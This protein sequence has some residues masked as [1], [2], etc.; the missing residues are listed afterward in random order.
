M[1]VINAPKASRVRAGT[2]RAS[3]RMTSSRRRRHR[4]LERDDPA[5]GVAS[6]RYDESLLSPGPSTGFTHKL[7]RAVAAALPGFNCLARSA[8]SALWPRLRLMALPVPQAL[9][10]FHSP[11]TASLLLASGRGSGQAVERDDPALRLGFARRRYDSD[12]SRLD[13]CFCHWFRQ[14][15]RRAHT[16]AYTRCHGIGRSPGGP[17]P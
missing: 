12:E 2:V 14:T 3:G 1:P 17:G 6:R 13:G 15:N 11:C 8:A 7:A 4:R 16:A 5:R 10:R 9:A